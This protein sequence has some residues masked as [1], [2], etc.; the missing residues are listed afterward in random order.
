MPGCSSNRDAA[1]FE[2]VEWAIAHPLDYSFLDDLLEGAQTSSS[3]DCIARA[4]SDVET[5]KAIGAT[6]S[7]IKPVEQR[8]GNMT[9]RAT[10]TRLEQELFRGFMQSQMHR[11]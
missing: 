10:G 11:T 4:S 5:R 8:K 6:Q 1:W 7:T 3:A 2:S 9:D